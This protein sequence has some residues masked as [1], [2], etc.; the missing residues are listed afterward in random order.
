[1]C[2]LVKKVNS[3]GAHHILSESHTELWWLYFDLELRYTTMIRDRQKRLDLK[4][5]FLLVS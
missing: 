3:C 2:V 1:M 5:A 4:P